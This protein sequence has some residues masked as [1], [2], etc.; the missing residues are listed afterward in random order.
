MSIL[1]FLF[2]AVLTGVYYNTENGI[3]IL[4]LDYMIYII[5]NLSTPLVR[6]FTLRKKLSLPPVCRRKKML[7]CGGKCIARQFKNT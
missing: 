1:S 3:L 7:V 5:F 6:L 4:F 2:D